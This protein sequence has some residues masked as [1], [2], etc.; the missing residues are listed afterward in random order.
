MAFPLISVFFQG[1]NLKN[2]Q[3]RSVEKVDD[4]GISYVIS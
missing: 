2:S 3:K 4:L 1:E